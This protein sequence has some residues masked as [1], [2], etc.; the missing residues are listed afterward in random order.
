MQSFPELS[1]KQQKADKDDIED[2]WA[3]SFLGAHNCNA[4]ALFPQLLS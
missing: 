2:G 4:G 3:C 1:N